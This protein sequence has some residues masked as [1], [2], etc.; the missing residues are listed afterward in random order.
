MF[1]L[2]ISYIIKDVGPLRNLW[3]GGEIGEKILGSVKDEFNGFRKNWI[4]ALMKR[5]YTDTSIRKVIKKHI[6]N[7]QNI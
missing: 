3:E 6:E 1:L 7:K 5:L 4:E 2:N